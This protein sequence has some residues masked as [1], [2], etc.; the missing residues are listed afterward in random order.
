MGGRPAIVDDIVEI[1]RE[2]RR[3]MH[4]TEITHAMGFAE[5]ER[6]RVS[7]ALNNRLETLP[8]VQMDIERVRRG[9]WRYVEPQVQA[10]PRQAPRQ[11]TEEPPPP[12]K[13]SIPE[14]LEV[15]G[16]TEGDAITKP[17]LIARDPD[18]GKIYKATLM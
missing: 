11:R 2:T 17:G 7:N 16:V 12:A 6:Y 10:P 8:D 13:S 9:V 15:L 14:M 3:E 18:T 5:P 4:V 1:L